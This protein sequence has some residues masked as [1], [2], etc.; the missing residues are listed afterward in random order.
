M[1]SVFQICVV[2]VCIL[3]MFC[4]RTENTLG[5]DESQEVSGEVLEGTVESLKD[6]ILLL[7]EQKARAVDSLVIATYDVEIGRIQEQVVNITRAKAYEEE[8]SLS[9]A[10]SNYAYLLAQGATGDTLLLAQ[11]LVSQLESLSDSLQRELESLTVKY[12]DIA[13]KDPSHTM[14]SSSTTPSSSFTQGS[15][16]SSSVIEGGSSGQ[17]P[18]ISFAP[19][20][21]P[22]VIDQGDQVAVTV[23]EDGSPKAFELLL[24]A[25]DVEQF[26]LSWEV[27]SHPSFGVLS[28]EKDAKQVLVDYQPAPNHAG[29]VT[30]VMTVS[31]SELSDTITVTVTIEPENDRPIYL[32]EAILVGTTVENEILSIDQGGA[33]TDSADGGILPIVSYIWYKDSDNSEYNGIAQVS[34]NKQKQLSNDDIDFYFYGIVACTDTHGAAVYDTTDYSAQIVPAQA[35]TGPRALQFKEVNDFIALPEMTLEVSDGFTFEALVYWDKNSPNKDGTLMEFSDTSGLNKLVLKRS[36]DKIHFVSSLG[37]GASL[38]KSH[39]GFVEEGHWTHVAVT[40]KNDGTATLYKNGFADK[41]ETFLI[42]AN[43]VSRTKN[44][45]GN[46]VEGGNAHLGLLDNVHIWERVLT[47]AEIQ[48]RLTQQV[49]GTE[50]GLKAAWNFNSISG[51]TLYDISLTYNGI[52]T[53]MTDDQWVESYEVKTVTIET[54]GGGITNVTGAVSVAKTMKFPITIEANEGYLLD[55]WSVISGEAEIGDKTQNVTWVSASENDAVISASFTRDTIHVEFEENFSSQ[56]DPQ[57]L[58][59][60]DAHGSVGFINN[61]GQRLLFSRNLVAGKYAIRV[62]Y[63]AWTWVP[64]FQPKKVQFAFTQSGQNIV[65]P[66]HQQCMLK[67]NTNN[68]YNWTT[69]DDGYL[70]VNQSGEYMLVTE[71]WL[72][73]YNVD[74]F[75]LI[76]VDE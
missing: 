25:T 74:W 6:T 55:Q 47:P 27:V 14:S 56:P 62:Q 1:V 11:E 72:D 15:V 71:F 39:K 22:P 53:N 50:T 19:L 76:P 38:L 65:F 45:L 23:S 48:Q 28:L 67:T 68:Y 66:P 64:M 4:S 26:E 54:T 69:S 58:Q 57:G 24:T 60:E 33:C 5:L 21:T 10:R 12:G 18:G 35:G 32:G 20:N 63:S 59:Y 70:I 52:V 16:N 3:L 41:S 44:V 43:N 2:L 61:S 36:Q 34:S 42:M 51:K 13:L 29:V 46:S 17:Q 31:D 40:V 9:I 30:F 49:Q 75:E 37:A 7:E 8:S 73:D